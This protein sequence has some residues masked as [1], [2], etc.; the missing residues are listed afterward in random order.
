VKAHQLATSPCSSRLGD[1][2][3]NFAGKGLRADLDYRV[4]ES[5]DLMCR[6]R[7][8]SVADLEQLIRDVDVAAT[9][10]PAWHEHSREQTA[11]PSNR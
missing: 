7:R 2:R 9:A 1:D 4:A 6:P 10:H 8:V 3:V 5:A 11:D